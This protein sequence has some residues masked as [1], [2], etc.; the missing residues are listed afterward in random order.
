MAAKESDHLYVTD[1]KVEFSETWILD[2]GHHSIDRMTVIYVNQ[3]PY[4]T[5]ITSNACCYKSLYP[6]LRPD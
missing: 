4:K 2:T 6:R 3:L 1:K 5:V